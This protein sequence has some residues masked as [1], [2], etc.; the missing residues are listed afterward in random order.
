M[1]AIVA[2]FKKE[3]AVIIGALITLVEALAVP[4]S[5]RIIAVLTFIGALITRQSVYAP[6]NVTPSA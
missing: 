5:G 1:S 2:A 4:D 3:P 6:A